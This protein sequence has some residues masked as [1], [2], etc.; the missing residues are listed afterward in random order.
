MFKM[1]FKAM[2]LP[3]ITLHILCPVD[4]L[5]MKRKG[6]AEGIPN[7]F[8]KTN[9]W[10]VILPVPFTSARR[11]TAATQLFKGFSEIEIW[12]RILLDHLRDLSYQ[13][14]L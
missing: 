5:F 9:Y 4:C 13:A 3:S 12:L 14:F 7:T 1:G 11:G 6:T 10:W 2:I 8:S